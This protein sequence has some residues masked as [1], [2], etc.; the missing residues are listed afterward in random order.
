MRLK[1]SRDPLVRAAWGF[2]VL[3]LAMFVLLQGRPFFSNASK[4]PSGLNSQLAI[5]FAR[6][7]DDAELI[8]GEAPSPDREVMR[9]KLYLDYAYIAVYTGLFVTLGALAARAGGWGKVAG[10]AGAVCGVAAGAFDIA[11]NRAIFAILDVSVKATS[12]PMI[13]SVFRAAIAKWILAAIAVVLLLSH[14]LHSRFSKA[15]P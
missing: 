14:Y 5:Q 9:V 4:P 11:E 2:G 7:V 6:S 8:L 13:D 15:K 12:Q 1:L 10:I 3:S